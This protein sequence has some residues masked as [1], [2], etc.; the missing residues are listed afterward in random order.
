[1]VSLK[2]DSHSFIHS[3]VDI[4]MRRSSVLQQ[5]T[6]TATMELIESAEQGKQR[7]TKKT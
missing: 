7:Q 3:L 6:A 4:L 1:M 2:I 5:S